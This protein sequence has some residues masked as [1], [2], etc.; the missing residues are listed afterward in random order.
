M[1]H[2]YYSTNGSMTMECVEM[3][4]MMDKEP[5]KPEQMSGRHEFEE[6]ATLI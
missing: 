4:D 3:G 5:M 1:F 2:S 6:D